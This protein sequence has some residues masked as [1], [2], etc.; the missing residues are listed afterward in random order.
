MNNRKKQTRF[1][2]LIGRLWPAL[3]ILAACNRTAPARVINTPIVLPAATVTPRASATPPPPTAADPTTETTAADLVPAAGAEPVELEFV[4][5]QP[6]PYWQTYTRTGDASDYVTDLLI[7][8]VGR[9]WIG[10]STG[11][12]VFDERS[13]RRYTSA[14]G[15]LADSVSALAVDPA[16]AIWVGYDG[17]GLS[18]FDGQQWQH[19]TLALDRVGNSVRD[20]AVDQ[21]G[22]LWLRTA[23]DLGRFDGHSWLLYRTEALRTTIPSPALAPPPDAPL[24]QAQV[25][26]IGPDH[27]AYGV[28]G[29]AVDPAGPVWLA[30]RQG[31]AAFDG[32]QWQQY[33]D[34]GQ[35]PYHPPMLV[36]AAAGQIWAAAA[37]GGVAVFDGRQVNR[38]NQL[39]GLPRDDVEAAAVDRAGRRWFGT[40][41]GASV[42]DGHTWLTYTPADGLPAGAIADIAV[43]TAGRVWLVTSTGTLA[44]FTPPA[45]PAPLPTPAGEVVPR[46]ID[47]TL[48]PTT[49]LTIGDVISVTWQA[50]GEQVDICF[51]S[52]TPNFCRPG[53][54]SGRQA[55]TVDESLF[56]A[57]VSG[58]WLSVTGNGRS[59]GIFEALDFQCRHSWFYADAP[60]SCAEAAPIYSAAAAQYFEH[61][62][63]IWSE[64]PDRFYIFFNEGQAFTQFDAAGVNDP[65][66][67]ATPEPLA[68]STGVVPTAEPWPTAPPSGLFEP[69]GGF[70]RVWQA[71]WRYEDNGPVAVRR[72]IGWATG[73]EFAFDTAYQCALGTAAYGPWDC[74]VRGPSG[75]VLSFAPQSTV[76]DKWIWTEK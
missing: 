59:T 36:D 55:I 49:A 46:I 13:W 6:N 23:F 54:A 19:Y 27:P 31:L 63:M 69:A 52:G 2:H 37:G 65:N 15:L 4:E 58:L 30:N 7:D 28:T 29:L 74:A 25:I 20:L 12:S 32:Q 73:P 76:R 62:L 40:N 61:G 39:T 57:S 22:Q 8:H 75:T 53:P 48:S 3:V 70:G 1:V 9:K 66:F 24:I 51:L 72:D 16:G 44:G 5:A 11:L 21:A 34:E 33:T 42:F 47:M 18:R 56:S 38:Y 71:A 50:V 17:D 41:A 43:D 45:A 64:Q 14:N 10:S 68:T 60:D 26:K 67:L 35:F